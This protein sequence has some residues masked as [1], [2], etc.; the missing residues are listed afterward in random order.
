MWKIKV[1]VWG[2]EREIYRVPWTRLLSCLLAVHLT[3]D[4][5]RSPASEQ[6]GLSPDVS[7]MCRATTVPEAICG[8]WERVAKQAALSALLTHLLNTLLISHS[9]VENS[10]SLNPGEEWEHF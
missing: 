7:L 10:K 9:C 4:V 6:E 1:Q 2:L 8:K 5:K 3:V